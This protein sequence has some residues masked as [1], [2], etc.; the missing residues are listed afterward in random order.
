MAT[1]KVESMKRGRFIENI[2]FDYLKSRNFKDL[3]KTT[4]EVDMRDHIDFTFYSD[5]LH[6]N[7]GID[8][9]APT[10]VAGYKP[11]EVNY[12]TF[13]NNQGIHGWLY[14]KADFAFIV[15]FEE[16]VIVKLSELREFMEDKTSGQ[17]P[18][19]GNPKKMYTKFHCSN[20]KAYDSGISNEKYRKS[21]SALFYIGDVKN[22]PS[23]KT[24]KHGKEKEIKEFYGKT[25][26]YSIN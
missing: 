1:D 15:T 24:V 10:F 26:I 11:S 18:L 23:S 8:V 9:K 21:V 6:K 3:S 25:N 20:F 5:K 13:V 17:E 14:G 16:F 19:F 12:A 2:V 22:L 4:D 7:I